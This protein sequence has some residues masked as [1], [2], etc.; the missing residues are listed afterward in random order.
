MKRFIDIGELKGYV[1]QKYFKKKNCCPWKIIAFIAVIALITVA[2]IL[3]IK[4]KEDH[5]LF[6]DDYEEDFDIDE[7]LYAKESDFDE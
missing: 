7:A 1:P 3:A 4:Y 5:E 2:V 6:S